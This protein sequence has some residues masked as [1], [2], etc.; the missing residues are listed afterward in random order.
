MEGCTSNEGGCSPAL[1]PP[2]THANRAS[3]FSVKGEDWFAANGGKPVKKKPP[4]AAELARREVRTVIGAVL[5]FKRLLQLRRRR[6]ARNRRSLP[7]NPL[8]A[9][10]GE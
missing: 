6:Q 4:T 8:S 7:K 2:A 10:D 5:K 9:E 1:R 3:S